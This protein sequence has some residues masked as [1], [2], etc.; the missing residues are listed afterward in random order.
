MREAFESPN[1]QPEMPTVE[2]AAYLIGYLWDAGPTPA[3]QVLTHAELRAWQEN[4]GVELSPWESRTLRRLSGDYLAE[5]FK[6]RRHDHP[7][8]WKPGGDAFSATTWKQT[9]RSF[10]KL[11]TL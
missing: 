1:Y 3:G 6:A 9:Q 7:A 8:P 4:N 5:T 11:V 10:R 2:A